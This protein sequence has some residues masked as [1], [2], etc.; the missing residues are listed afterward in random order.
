M[1]SVLCQRCPRSGLQHEVT[2]PEPEI[3]PPRPRSRPTGGPRICPQVPQPYRLQRQAGKI[4][5]SLWWIN[6]FDIQFSF[7]LKIIFLILK[8]L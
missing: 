5:I 6:Y 3:R 8:D 4:F 1:Y 2:G 7:V